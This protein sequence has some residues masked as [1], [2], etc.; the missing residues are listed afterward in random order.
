MPLE[1]DV[2]PGAGDDGAVGTNDGAT[3]LVAPLPLSGCAGAGAGLTSTVPGGTGSDVAGRVGAGAVPTGL[4]VAE[5]GGDG[6]AGIAD[7][8]FGQRPFGGMGLPSGHVGVGGL[9]GGVVGGTVGG[10]LHLDKSEV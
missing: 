7:G 2:G 10:V 3:V 5:A 9:V 4:G 8:F 1:V 6:G